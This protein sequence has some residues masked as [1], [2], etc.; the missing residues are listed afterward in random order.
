MTNQEELT[1]HLLASGLLK[2]PGLKPA[3][4]KIDRAKFVPPEFISQAYEDNPLPLGKGQTISQPAV[5]AFML[6]LLQVGKGL[7]VLEVGSGS[8]FVTALLA[9]LVGSNGLIVSLEIVPDLAD[10]ARR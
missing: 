10:Q 1:N 8:G 7:K 9:E 3:W 6:D 4:L 2:F 5:V